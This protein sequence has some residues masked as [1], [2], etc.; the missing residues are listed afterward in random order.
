MTKKTSERHGE[1]LNEYMSGNSVF[2][3]WA[4][5]NL[6]KFELTDWSFGQLSMRWDI[7]DRFI[8]PD[9]AMFG[10]HVSSVA[11]HVM[12]LLSMSVLEGNEDRFVTSRLE[13]NFFRPVQKPL[14]LIEARA[15]NTSR[16]L[17]HGE[18]DFLTPARKLS[19]RVYATQV[20]RQANGT[21]KLLKAT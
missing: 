11:D 3:S 8:M 14:A 2:H 21:D 7:D 15:T 18:A 20:R 16:T 10:G 13:V 19:A 1:I 5:H 6:G 4:E 12:G 17:I 9:G